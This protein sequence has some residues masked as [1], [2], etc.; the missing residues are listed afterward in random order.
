MGDNTNYISTTR[1]YI[2]QN[3][4]LAIQ[5][6]AAGLVELLTNSDD[7]F[8]G[9]G[10]ATEVHVDLD[11][12]TQVCTVVDQGIGIEHAT[13]VGKLARLGEKSNKAGARGLFSRGA[14]D[15]SELGEVTFNS[16]V[17]NLVKTVTL[18]RDLSYQES[19]VRPVTAR[20][21]SVW[22]VKANGVHVSMQVLSMYWPQDLEEFVRKFAQ[23]PSMVFLFADMTKTFTYRIKLVNGAIR[24]GRFIYKAPPGVTTVTEYP[25][26]G[27][28]GVTAS[29]ALTI[30]PTRLVSEEI[31]IIV[32][33][34][35]GVYSRESFSPEIRA[36]PYMAFICGTL[37]CEYIRVLM[38]DIEVADSEANPFPIITPTRKGLSPAHPFTRQLYATAELFIKKAL[39][40]VR[41]RN[42]NPSQEEA[43]INEAISSI[44]IAGAEI[45]DASGELYYV[46]DDLLEKELAMLL[47][48]C[49]ITSMSEAQANEQLAPKPSERPTNQQA[50]RI[51]GSFRLSVNFT[52]DESETPVS[53]ICSG[54]SIEITIHVRH[55]LVQDLLVL[56]VDGTIDGLTNPHSKMLLAGLVA[57]A[58]CKIMVERQLAQKP[59][60]SAHEILS[61][62][63]SIEGTKADH[64]ARKLFHRI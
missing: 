14:K 1:R 3:R 6:L 62:Y 51:M 50:R 17:D 48:Q 52:A 7:A 58:L 43:T 20:D 35:D 9:T 42:P 15:V 30:S 5:N 11:A 61:L 40:E 49:H 13:L 45:L 25:V 57:R 12:Q 4:S 53:F 31:G 18:R 55:Y 64:I 16:V 37:R 26:L 2:R 22:G 56:H 36:N 41:A 33:G 47:P 60:M 21:R 10:R 38:E 59:E 27:Y 39:K 29:L 46:E 63:T 54:F 32:C 44:Q 24:T 23:E 34:N 28:D 8:L 19:N